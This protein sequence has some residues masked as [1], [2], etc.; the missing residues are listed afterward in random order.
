MPAERLGNIPP[1]D[2]VA[3]GGVCRLPFGLDAGC[4][5]VAGAADAA[6]RFGVFL[7]VLVFVWLVFV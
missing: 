1:N 2:R 3:F 5:L 7:A 6:G 4:R